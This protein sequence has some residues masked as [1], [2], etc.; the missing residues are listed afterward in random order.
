MHSPEAE[1][2]PD[3][4]KPAT[5]IEGVIPFYGAT[6]PE[7]FAIERTSMDR[8]GRVIR[9]L[10]ET[11]PEH[12]PVLDVGAGDGFTAEAL[13]TPSRTVVALE[14]SAGMIRAER[15]L[16]WCRGKAQALPFAD[17]SFEGAYAT[18][19]YFFLGH[20]DISAD[21]RRTVFPHGW[22]EKFSRLGQDARNAQT[23]DATGHGR[24]LAQWARP[25][26]QIC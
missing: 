14:P 25:D 3:K 4:P 17:A 5:R 16:R 18:W 13:T 23:S 6:D 26:V 8:A 19:A 15:P 24:D 1:S 11:L 21:G 2:A 10:D 12:S 20:H 7:L 22:Q 9:F